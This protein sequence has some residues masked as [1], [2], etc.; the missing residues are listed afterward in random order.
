MFKKVSFSLAK[1]YIPK[2]RKSSPLNSYYESYFIIKI[3]K[4]VIFSIVTLVREL[5]TADNINM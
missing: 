1:K 2:M 4:Y 5:E 3:C